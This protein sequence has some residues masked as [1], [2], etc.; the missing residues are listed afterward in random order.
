MPS[1]VRPRTMSSTSSAPIV[2]GLDRTSALLWAMRFDE[3]GC[4]HIVD[5]SIDFPDFGTFGE[6]FL[7]LHFDL[8]AA[9]LDAPIREGRLGPQGLA[10][11]AFGPDNHQRV[12]FKDNH[13]GGVVADLGCVA[14][15]DEQDDVSGRLHFVLGP[16]AL[17]SGGHRPVE[18]PEATRMAA[19]DG[20]RITSP[21]IL[22]ETL[23]GYVIAAIATSGAR[24]SDELDGIE[25]HILDEP[26]RGDCGRL[27]RVRRDAVRLHRQLLGLRAV[28]HRLEA[29]GAAQDL[30]PEAITAAARVA[31][32]LDAL[33]RD[34][35]LNAERSRL[36]QEELSARVAEQSNRQ[37]YTLSVLTALFMPPTLITGFFGINTKGL[38]LADNENGS[39]VVLLLALGS[40]VFAYWLIRIFGIRASR[41]RGR[42]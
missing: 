36:L 38:P 5:T 31:Q 32:R 3:H 14:D 11:C 41:E 29:D 15:G 8:G 34:I 28:F 25:D 37:L 18:S 19:A 30:P 24:L 35:N 10:A 39:L 40:A 27:G 33:V 1:A 20:A 6:G 17:V 9:N 4:A 42:G 13:V 22:L 26:V 16:R 7:W 2:P 12:T 21:V 23:I